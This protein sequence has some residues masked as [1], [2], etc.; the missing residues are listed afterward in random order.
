MSK[1]GSSVRLT[2]VGLERAVEWWADWGRVEA[3]FWFLVE[4]DCGFRMVGRASEETF[5]ELER[6][7]REWVGE[8]ERRKHADSGG[9]VDSVPSG[10]SANTAKRVE[11]PGEDGLA[12]QQ[13]PAMTDIISVE[14][15]WEGLEK[16]E[17]FLQYYSLIS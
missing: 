4:E 1:L 17:E 5:V 15:E 9:D 6:T 7:M 3:E 8:R 14:S 10:D 16:E 2:R 13:R 12:Q 11:T